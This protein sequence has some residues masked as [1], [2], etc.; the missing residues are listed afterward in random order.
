MLLDT[1]VIRTAD[2]LADHADPTCVAACAERL[3]QASRSVVHLDRGRAI[4]NEYL[5]QIAGR[6]P[7]QVGTRFVHLLLQNQE[8]PERCQQESIT[9]H[10]ARGYVEFPDDPRLATFDDDDRKFVAV[11]VAADPTPAIVNAVDSD[12]EP[13]A[14]ALIDHG[15]L[16]EQLCPHLDPLLSAKP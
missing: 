4:L 9:A 5:G 14:G 7:Y 12:W 1:N 3:E 11:A 2:G 15:I 6:P 16:V 8:N 10:P 13:V